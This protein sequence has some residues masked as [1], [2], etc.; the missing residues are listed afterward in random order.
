[1]LFFTFAIYES[2]I[3]RDISAKLSMHSFISTGSFYIS[4][5]FFTLCLFYCLVSVILVRVTDQIFAFIA[6]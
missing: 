4:A 3:Q 6:K 1:M 5:T 2:G